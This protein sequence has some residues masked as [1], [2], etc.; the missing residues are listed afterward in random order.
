MNSNNKKQSIAE[1]IKAI[2]NE[3]DL[4]QYQLAHELGVASSTLSEIENEKTRSKF[5]I[6]ENLAKKFHVNLYYL[7]FDEG[8]MFLDPTFFQ[9][10]MAE[11]DT[12]KKEQIRKFFRDFIKSP[13]YQLLIMAHSRKIMSIDGDII[14]NE[15][16]EYDYKKNLH[17]GDKNE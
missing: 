5:L 15:I 12:I 16:N 14:Q 8:D 1:R 11:S 17:L 3:L 2:R 10:I 7:L 4:K 13:T 6:L 9:M